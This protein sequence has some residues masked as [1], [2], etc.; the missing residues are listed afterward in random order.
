VKSEFAAGVAAICAELPCAYVPAP[1]GVPEPVPAVVIASVYCL[2]VN[3]AV[4]VVSLVTTTVAGLVVPVGQPTPLQPVKSEFAAGVAAICAELPCAY[5]PAPVVVPDPVPAVV[6]ASAYCLS[7][8]VA[9]HVVSLV[10]TTVA[11]LL[12][13]VG[14]PTP[15]HPVKSEF[16]AGVAE[17]CTDVPAA[18]VPAPVV[19]PEPVPAVG[20]ASVYCFRVNVAVHVVSPFTTTVAGLVVPVGQPVPL[21][22]AKVE[23]AAGVAVICVALPARYRPA[24]VVVPAP[25]PALLIVSTYCAVNVA[26][27]VMSP[28][29]TTVAGLV[30]PDGHPVVP[31]QLVKTPV[32]VPAA[33]ICT[34]VP[35][36]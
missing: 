13:P 30:E 18:Y 21:H 2:S 1:V 25:V 9:V 28:S 17:I 8:N 10:T 16:A 34:G 24:P 3:V 36:A 4:H 7:V 12:G 22:P 11:G 19:V 29:I 31:L 27:H 33:E 5:V 14:Q 20:I 15:L 23:L 35:A 26:V 32:P 6:M